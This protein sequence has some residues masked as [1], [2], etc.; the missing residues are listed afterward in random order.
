MGQCKSSLARSSFAPHLGITVLAFS[1]FACAQIAGLEEPIDMPVPAPERGVPARDT[2]PRP[3]DAKGGLDGDEKKNTDDGDS[4]DLGVAQPSLDFQTVGCGVA[5]GKNLTLINKGDKPIPYEV[6]MPESFAPDEKPV[7]TVIDRQTGTIPAKSH[8]TV[9]IAALPRIAG[10]VKGNVV[11]TSGAKYVTVPVGVVGVGATLEWASSTADIGETRT[12]TDGITKV[13]LKNVGTGTAKIDSFSGMTADFK[14]TGPVMPLEIPVDGEAEITFTL[15]KGSMAGMLLS[16]NIK[17]NASGLCTAA[18]AIA[19]SGRRISSDVIVS[20]ADW[21]KRDCYTNPTDTRSILIKNYFNKEV[22]WT[23]PTPGTF[24]LANGVTTGTVP[25][26]VGTTPGT[27]NI[28]YK[29]PALQG[30]VPV[31][32]SVKVN[33][34]GEGLGAPGAGDHDVALKVDVRGA[35]V[36]LVPVDAS[37]SF[38]AAQGG[39]DSEAY[40]IKNTGNEPA[41]LAWSFKRTNGPA[42]W[43]D[44]PQETYT[45]AARTTNELIRYQPTGYAEDGS[46]NTATLTPA[47]RNGSKKICNADTALKVVNLTGNKP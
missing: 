46:A 10:Q 7:F 44:L 8:V 13:K 39:S 36:E 27:V 25:A 34:T 29:P 5:Q 22:T 9:E 16:T 43:A 30:P 35:L 12:D 42:A 31:T 6:V 11:V 23:V 21:G 28:P 2:S 38:K 1:L 26:A 19:V 24:T 37:L 18:P 17:P 4:G 33:I 41:W 20:G 32:E 40:Q 47:Q 14:A 3:T 45:D 15:T